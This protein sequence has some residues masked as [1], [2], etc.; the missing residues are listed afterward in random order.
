MDP[1]DGPHEVDIDHPAPV[2]E[3]RLLDRPAVA[4]AGVVV[5]DVDGAVGGEHPL[6]ELGDGEE[7]LTDVLD[8]E[9]VERVREF[10]TAGV[11]RLWDQLD[12][13]GA[14]IELPMYGGVIRPR[15]G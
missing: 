3:R 13:R 14:E 8:L 12:R 11:S 2:L 1:V 7:L 4:D 15:P 10:G 5:E 6:G 9:A